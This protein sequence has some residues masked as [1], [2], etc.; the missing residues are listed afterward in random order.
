MNDQAL[1]DD[2]GGGA[3]HA[4]GPRHK[5]ECGDA[6]FVG[7]EAGQVTGV[8]FARAVGPVRFGRGVEMSAGAHAVA[9]RAVALFMHMKA[10]FCIGFESTNFTRHLH[11]I[12]GL[13]KR[14][15]TSGCVAPGG[16]QLGGSAVARQ[17]GGTAR[18]RHN[19]QGRQGKSKTNLHDSNSS[20]RMNERGIEP[21]TKAQSRKPLRESP[22]KCA[23]CLFLGQRDQ[24]SQSPVVDAVLAQLVIGGLGVVAGGAVASTGLL[25]NAAVFVVW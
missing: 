5:A 7:L 11:A 18:Q 23:L 21:D 17:V 15:R 9:A 10:V 19:S 2:V 25:E 14:H 22:E 3:A 4:D 16:L 6:V 20:V 24:P 8:V 13:Y 1:A 12:A